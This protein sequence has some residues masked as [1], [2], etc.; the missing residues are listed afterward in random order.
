[1]SSESYGT[2]RCEGN[3]E[4]RCVSRMPAANLYG[5][6]YGL[7]YKKRN[8]RQH[9]LDDSALVP[10]AGR[11]KVPLMEGGSKQAWIEITMRFSHVHSL[12][13][14]SSNRT[15]D[16]YCHRDGLF[17]SQISP[18]IGIQNFKIIVVNPS[19]MPRL[20]AVKDLLQVSTTSTDT[21]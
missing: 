19:K 16:R 4:D 7:G 15:V 3:Q 9:F 1:M 8:T 14:H 17:L 10:T 12:R 13:P 11:P 18:S 2:K 21:H 6:E 20:G 5:G